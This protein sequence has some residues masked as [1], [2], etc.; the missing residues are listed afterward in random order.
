[1]TQTSHYCL[2]FTVVIHSVGC[3]L[4]KLG[5]CEWCIPL[6]GGIDCKSA[7]CINGIPDFNLAGVVWSF[8]IF[9]Q[10]VGTCE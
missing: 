4:D 7:N 2:P 9:N 1:M 8:G 6:H 5:S 3:C 10:F